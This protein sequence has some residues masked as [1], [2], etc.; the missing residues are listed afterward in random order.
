MTRDKVPEAFK[1]W[2]INA[3][4]ALKFSRKRH[5]L[6]HAIAAGQERE[7]ARVLGTRHIVQCPSCGGEVDTHRAQRHIPI[8]NGMVWVGC[9]CRTCHSRFTIEATKER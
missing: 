1:A 9:P 6:I 5:E 3:T 7:R 2:A 4:A 8:D